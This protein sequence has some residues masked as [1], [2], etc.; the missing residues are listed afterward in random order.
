[1][2]T[3]NAIDPM[4]PG[5]TTD[6]D[7][8]SLFGTDDVIA[9]YTREDAIA[10]GVIID[11]RDAE[12]SRRAFPDSDLDAAHELVCQTFG[13]NGVDVPLGLSAALADLLQKAIA[14][15]RQGN[16][17]TG[18][19]NDLFF[20]AFFGQFRRFALQAIEQEGLLRP[21]D[22]TIRG[23]GRKS[24]YQLLVALDGDGVTFMLP[25]DR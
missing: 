15:P 7:I 10:D 20:M 12:S 23:A 5:R 25:G 18:L 24:K 2:N 22:V 19:L 21:F 11:L 1:M 16:D 6:D 17:L 14:N 13:D 3:P 4:H 9:C 8:S